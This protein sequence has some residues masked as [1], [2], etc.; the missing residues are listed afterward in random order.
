MP[1]KPLTISLVIPAYNEESYLAGCL[2]AALAQELPFS[3]II[4]VDNNSTDNT[5]LVAGQ[6]PGVKIIKESTQG[7]VHARTT[8]F[9]AARGDIIARIDADTLL[10]ADWTRQLHAIFEESSVDAVSGRME[11][12]NMAASRLLNWVDLFFRRYFAVVLGRE[13]ALQAANMAMRRSAWQTVRSQTCGL[14]NL[15]EDFD[16]AIHTNLAGYQVVFDERLVARIGYR[17]AASSFMTFCRYV[18]LSPQTYRAHRLKSRFW[19]Y[20]VV[21][22]AIA[23]YLVLKIMHRG[24]DLEAERFSLRKLLEP[25]A[26][27]RVNPATYVD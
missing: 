14:R 6:F 26:D 2:Q 9:D 24:Y 1:K 7:V 8:G 10:P 11:Y 5:A 20:P 22:V 27:I 12:H 17:Q 23:C 18:W 21:A 19:M 4:V 13:V 3:E 16:L 25:A 15:H